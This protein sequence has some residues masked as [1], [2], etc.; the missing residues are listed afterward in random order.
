MSKADEHSPHCGLC[1]VP[2]KDFKFHMA[3]KAH[4]DKVEEVA[5]DPDASFV[6]QALAN[7]MLVDRA[8][9]GMDE[10]VKGLKKSIG[11]L[12]E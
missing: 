3:S 11:E 7:K 12:D 1:Q 6:M 9:K 4:W 10:G 5:K 8:M 2:V